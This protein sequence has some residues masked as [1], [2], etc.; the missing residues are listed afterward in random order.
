[1]GQ[2]KTVEDVVYER[3]LPNTPRVLLCVT[4]FGRMEPEQPFLKGKVAA[5][6]MSLIGRRFQ[7]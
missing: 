4:L 1:M 7:W 3:L 5:C 6:M 2:S